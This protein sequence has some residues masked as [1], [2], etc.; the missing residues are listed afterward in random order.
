[1]RKRGV[2]RIADGPEFT[3]VGEDKIIGAATWLDDD[4]GRSKRYQVLTVKHGKIVDMQ[5]FSS[6]R[7]AERFARRH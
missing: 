7:A 2:G 4:G 6:R 3:E 5:G 1:M